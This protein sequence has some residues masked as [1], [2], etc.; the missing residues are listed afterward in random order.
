MLIVCAVSVGLSYWHRKAHVM[1]IVC[2]VSVGLSY[3]HHKADVYGGWFCKRGSLA[4][5]REPLAIHHIIFI[6][7]NL[8]LLSSPQMS[9]L[10][11][12]NRSLQRLSG[13][14]SKPTSVPS[15]STSSS[16]AS[17]CSSS[18]PPLSVATT[19]VKC[20]SVG[21]PNV[22]I[23]TPVKKVD[24]WETNGP[25]IEP[26]SPD[27]NERLKLTTNTIRNVANC[28]TPLFEAKLNSL[29]KKEVGVNMYNKKLSALI[30]EQLLSG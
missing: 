27:E 3:W 17:Q 16:T 18:N 22:S 2:A 8:C 7:I 12:R 29:A 4:R 13:D 25:C 23:R 11:Y 5:Y 19:V 6:D 26:V 20:S 30:S 14:G 1:L 21:Q 10:E 9:L 24:N 28:N 15:Q